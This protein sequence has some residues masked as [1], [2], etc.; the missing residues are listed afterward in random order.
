MDHHPSWLHMTSFPALHRGASRELVGHPLRAE[1]S[2]A[3][4]WG[5]GRA[6]ALHAAVAI[7][8]LGGHSP[9]RPVSVHTEAE[10][11]DDRPRRVGTDQP[12]HNHEDLR[13]DV[14]LARR[15]RPPR[16]PPQ[17]LRLP[18]LLEARAALFACCSTAA[19]PAWPA[20]MAVASRCPWPD[21]TIPC[22]VWGYT[23]TLIMVTGYRGGCDGP[24][25][26]RKKG[27]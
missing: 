27:Q 11:I 17:G 6:V 26:R 8:R 16:R 12:V 23:P 13:G 2:P 10:D 21:R 4:P 9:S 18:G 25:S 1:G 19:A 22:L 3:A 7:S 5:G 15:A 20:R 14:C 24:A